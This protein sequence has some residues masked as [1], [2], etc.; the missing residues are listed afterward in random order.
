M[1]ALGNYELLFDARRPLGARHIYEV[2]GTQRQASALCGTPRPPA[3]Y[4][5]RTVGSWRPAHPLRV[6]D[7]CEGILEERG[8]PPLLPPEGI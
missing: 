2:I 6:C 3:G 7:V 1:A 4:E 8:G 5:R